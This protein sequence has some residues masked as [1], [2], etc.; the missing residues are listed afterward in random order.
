MA[1]HRL[2][3]GMVALAAA[4]LF[5]VPLVA[6]A[7]SG[8]LNL[9]SGRHYDTDEKLYSDFTAQ[10]GIRINLIEGTE[11]QIIERI[12]SEG[13]N[14]PADVLIT[15]DAG[16]LWRAEQ[17]KILAPTRSELL[18]SRIPASV[19]HP[20]GY[21]FGFS[22]RARVI[23][24]SKDR[25]NP[26]ELST[27]EALAEPQWKGRVAIRSS[28]NVYN[29]S[30][31]GSMIEANGLDA[32]EAWARGIVAN[33]AR[34]PAGGDTDQIKAIASG[35]ADVAIANHYYYVRMLRSSN[36]AEVAEA[37]QVGIFFPNQGTGERGTHVNVS[38]AGA[39]ATAPNPDSALAFLEYLASDSAQ[40]YFALGNTEFP[41][42]EGIEVHPI[43]ASW[44]PFKSDDLSTLR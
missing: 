32:S 42:V 7:Q 15:V 30:L 39:V 11:D 5:V 1:F 29:Q 40:N 18:E 34:Q 16:R 26:S 22:K 23:F 24:Y 37:E 27:Y 17:A 2:R 25:V 12:R 35:V 19:R 41:V 6:G 38:G 9:Y 36:P 10:T 44:G 21:W 4:L 43:P 28:T 3:L 14:S 8:E 20:E 13:Q 31:V 33:L